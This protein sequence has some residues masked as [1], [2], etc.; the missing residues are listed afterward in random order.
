MVLVLA[1]G[2]LILAVALYRVS[3]RL[4]KHETKWRRLLADSRGE[5][6]ETLLY[7]HLAERMEM[8]RQM[9]DLDSRLGVLEETI[10]T[11]KR[12]LGL[13]RYDA[14]PDVAGSQSFALAV[15]DDK[16]DGAILSSIVGRNSCRV[17]CKPL[18]GG[19]SE[20]DLSQEE[21][22]AVRSAREGGVRTILS[23]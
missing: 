13:V 14:F 11:S 19:R 23:P 22:R 8:S 21:Q 17:F 1:A 5:S 6:L 2:V 10:L 12:F 18:I 4:Q 7:D 16:G 20:R 9:S 3:R 15:Y